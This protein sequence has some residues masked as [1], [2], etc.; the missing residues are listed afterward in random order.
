VSSSGT[1]SIAMAAHRVVM[2]T[3]FIYA[4]EVL[5]RERGILVPFKDPNSIAREVVSILKKPLKMAA[6]G[7]AAQAY[8]KDMGWASVGRQYLELMDLL[9]TKQPLPAST[10]DSATDDQQ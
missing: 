7:K 3:P 2:A 6:M 1:V 9:P 10:T 5:S 4:K 8:T